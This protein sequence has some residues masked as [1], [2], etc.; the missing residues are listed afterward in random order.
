MFDPIAY[1]FPAEWPALALIFT[2]TAAVAFLLMA[3]LSVF[4]RE[5]E[6]E[7]E[8]TPRL[9][10]PLTPVIAGLLPTTARGRAAVQKDLLRAGYFEPVALVNFLA[11]RSL[12]TYV[13][14]IAGEVGA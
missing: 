14:L 4:R 3:S 5:D 12:T 2:A 13:P 6:A 7:V 10:G 8:P 11:V 1:G 9:F